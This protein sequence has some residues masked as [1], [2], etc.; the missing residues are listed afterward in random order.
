MDGRAG[1]DAGALG[2]HFQKLR[3]PRVNKKGGEPDH[4]WNLEGMSH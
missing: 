4:S 3:N 2:A 1:L